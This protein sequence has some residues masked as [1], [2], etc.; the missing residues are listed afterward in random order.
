MGEAIGNPDFNRANAAASIETA[1]EGIALCKIWLSAVGALVVLTFSGTFLAL[2]KIS[3]LGGWQRGV[4]FFLMFLELFEIFIVSRVAENLA[5]YIGACRRYAATT[6]ALH[7]P[8]AQSAMVEVDK[9]KILSARPYMTAAITGI[10]LLLTL[11]AVYGVMV[12]AM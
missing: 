12:F 5:T 3:N 8:L 1:S 9:A 6:C 7:D 2:D 11:L 4:L 10:M